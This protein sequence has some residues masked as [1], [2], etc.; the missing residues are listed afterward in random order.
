[1]PLALIAVVGIEATVVIVGCIS[2][3]E[4]VCHDKINALFAPVCAKGSGL[5]EGTRIYRGEGARKR[6]RLSSY[7]NSVNI[8]CV[9]R[10]AYV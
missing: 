3:A 10:S 7:F 1:M 9:G 8:G 5:G 4:T 2:V 6:L